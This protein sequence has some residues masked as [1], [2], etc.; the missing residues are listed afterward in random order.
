M[1]LT[2][3]LITNATNSTRNTKL[4]NTLSTRFDD[5][6]SDRNFNLKVRTIKT[7]TKRGFM[8]TKEDLP[9]LFEEVFLDLAM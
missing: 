2:E 9:R 6:I 7:A 8:I 4:L 1:D 3:K 5:T